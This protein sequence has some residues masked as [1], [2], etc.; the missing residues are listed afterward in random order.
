MTA[1]VVTPVD[2]I[3]VVLEH[4]RDVVFPSKFPD[5]TADFEAPTNPTEFVRVEWV[6][7]DQVQRIAGRERLRLQ[8]WGST[9]DSDDH[10]RM[11][12]ARSLIAHLWRDLSAERT[13]GPINLPDP[14]DPERQITQFTIQLLLPGEQ[15]A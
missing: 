9:D 13:A 10:E 8:V 15:E 12:V 3:V 4:L 5:W 6:G 2:P 1:P 14:A 11:R 7:G